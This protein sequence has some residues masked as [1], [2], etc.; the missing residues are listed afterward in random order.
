MNHE[1]EL[2]DTLKYR[3]AL[4]LIEDYY[5]VTIMKAKKILQAAGYSVNKIT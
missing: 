5:D 4:D 2:K 1:I 3:Q